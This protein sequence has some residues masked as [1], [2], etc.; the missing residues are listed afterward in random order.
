MHRVRFTGSPQFDRRAFERKEM[1]VGFDLN[2]VRDRPLRFRE[3]VEQR[4]RF[5]QIPDDRHI[6]RVQLARL[7]EIGQTGFPASLPA[8]D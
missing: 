6:P 2:S 8:V 5:R 1:S 7:F 3:M 4:I